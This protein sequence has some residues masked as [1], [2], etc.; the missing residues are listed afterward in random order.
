M[1][2]SKF[3]VELLEL[4]GMDK[5]SFCSKLGLT[6]EQFK[7]IE[8]NEPEAATSVK[9]LVKALSTCLFS[10]KADKEKAEYINNKLAQAKA[11]VVTVS[12]CEHLPEHQQT[13]L[14]VASELIEK[15]ENRV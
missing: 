10:T 5:E 15:A 6:P 1:N 7:K 2:L 12:E 4:S 3:L 8:N 9:V 11:I 14:S 13:T